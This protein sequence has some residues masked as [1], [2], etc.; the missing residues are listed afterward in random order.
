M[1]IIDQCREADVPVSLCGEM[2]GS[3]LDAMA[4]VGLGMRSL[5]MNPSSIGSGQ[6]DD[7]EPRCDPACAGSWN[8]LITLPDHS[9]REKLREFAHDHGVMI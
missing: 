1:S 7:P 4:L 8:S 2:A 3:T 9:V 6:G 5:S